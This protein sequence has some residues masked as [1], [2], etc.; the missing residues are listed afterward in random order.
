M[1]LKHLNKE[2]LSGYDLM[3]SFETVGKKPS[4]GYIYPLLKDL[5]NKKFISVKKDKRRKVYSITKKGKEL[6]KNLEDK[7]NQMIKAMY[8]VG[9][10]KEMNNFLRFKDYMEN[11]NYS[12]K[13]KNII[14]KLH[15][16]IFSI[17]KTKKEENKKQM[18]KILEESI[19]KIKSI[20]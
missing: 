17:F 14:E 16:S 18:R 10:K 8:E 5:Q 3:K 7:H 11:G 15:K 2:S 6:L 9:D 12:L 13:D 1:V 20:K 19:K 4:P